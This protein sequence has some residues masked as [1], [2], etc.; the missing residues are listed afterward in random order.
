MEERLKNLQKA[1]DRTAFKNIEFTNEHQEKIRKQNQV[2]PLKH[3]IL[4]M[5]IEAKSGIELTQLLHVRGV[6]QIVENEG[7]IYSLLHEAEQQGLLSSSWEEGVKYYQ[8]SKYSKKQLHQEGEHVK[9]SIKERILGVR[10][11]V[12]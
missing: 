1:V 4:S 3:R 12:E 10:M 5:L 2:L 8:L 7:L 9:L 11:H 6:E